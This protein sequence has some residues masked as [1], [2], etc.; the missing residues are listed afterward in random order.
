MPNPVP[1]FAIGSIPVTS[2]VKSTLVPST[3]SRTALFNVRPVPTKSLIVS[4]PIVKLPTT[5]SVLDGA[6]VPSP[7]LLPVSYNSEF[8]SVLPSNHTDR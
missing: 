8:V 7:M 1:P 2:D 5:S 4:P 6:V 3:A